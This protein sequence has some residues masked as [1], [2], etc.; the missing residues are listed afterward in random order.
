[1]NWRTTGICTFK[2]RY[3]LLVDYPKSPEKFVKKKVS[4]KSWNEL[5]ELGGGRSP[6]P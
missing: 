4:I 3:I 1:M 6:S 2:L 5:Y